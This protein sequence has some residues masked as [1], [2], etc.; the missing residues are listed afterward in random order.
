VQ[1]KEPVLSLE[2]KT[3]THLKP[4]AS[5]VVDE[6]KGRG[7]NLGNPR[8]VRSI[9]EIDPEELADMVW[10]PTDPRLKPS[11]APFVPTPS[12]RTPV[13]RQPAVSSPTYSTA[14]SQPY[15]MLTS[16]T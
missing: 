4:S 14:A 8:E 1:F 11:K 12:Y 3:E 16:P 10:S 15:R 6:A 2:P 9:L 13:D 7:E 5:L